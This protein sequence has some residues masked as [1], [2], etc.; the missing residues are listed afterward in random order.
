MISVLTLTYQRHKILEEA[1]QS[2]LM[3][4]FED[5]E[6]V[7]LNDSPEV[8]YI[9][10]HPKVR[11]INCPERF[12][13]IGKKLEYGFSICK[14]DLIYRLDDDDLLAPNALSTMASYTTEKHDIYRCHHAFYFEHNEFRGL[15]DNVNNG[16]CYSAEYARKIKFPDVSI[17]E[18]VDITFNQ[19][20]DIFTANDGKCSM[21]YRW[22]MG[23]YHI[24]GLGVE[25][26]DNSAYIFN[27]V[28]GLVNKESGVIL[29]E[30]HFDKDYYGLLK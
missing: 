11:V 19:G 10:N 15:S 21:I 28:D 25:H 7:V 23:T 17:V 13:S 30:P 12:P 27:R 8:E 18:D 24:S 14:G 4:D 3:Q 20:A 22:G 5:A 16:N 26:A 9:F 1:I 2:F 29:L 6:M